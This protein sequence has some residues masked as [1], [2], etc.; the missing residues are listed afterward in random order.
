MRQKLTIRLKSYDGELK[1]LEKEFVA[2]RENTQQIQSRHQL[3]GAA[4]IDMGESGYSFFELV[5]YFIVQ[6][7]CSKGTL[8]HWD[9]LTKS[10]STPIRVSKGQE[11]WGQPCRK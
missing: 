11:S 9:K 4:T 3:L 6:L 1:R 10:W 7:K 2:T 5:I 8:V